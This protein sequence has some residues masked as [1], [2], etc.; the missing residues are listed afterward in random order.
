MFPNAT[1]GPFLKRSICIQ[2][3]SG[4]FGKAYE[5]LLCILGAF[6]VPPA[7][8]VPPPRS[9]PPSPE[10]I[11]STFPSW[12]LH[13]FSACCPFKFR[14]SFYILPLFLLFY[15]DVGLD[16][17]YSRSVRKANGKE[18]G[19]SQTIRK[20]IEKGFGKCSESAREEYGN[21]KTK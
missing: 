13:S 21:V 9:P 7:P 16:S 17:T 4:L 6:V 20:T 8:A 14:A 2:G 10:W 19:Y 5:S 18:T 3:R 1:N 15:A 12:L 11:L